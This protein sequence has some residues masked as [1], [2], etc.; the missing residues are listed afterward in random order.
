MFDYTNILNLHEFQIEC[1]EGRYNIPIIK[2]EKCIPDKLIDFCH[3]LRSTQFSSGVHFFLD[4]NRFE[5]IWRLPWRY[6]PHLR[7]FDVVLSPDFSLYTDMP[8]AMKIWNV[9]RS[10]LLG[11]MMQ[12][13]GCRVIPTVSWAYVDS[14]DYC[15]EGIIPGSVVAVSTVG[16]MYSQECRNIF[17]RGFEAMIEKLNPDKIILYGKV[18][19]ELK[20]GNYEIISFSN[21]SMAW[22][23]GHRGVSYKEKQ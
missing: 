22:K 12:R 20:S 21:T 2:T 4:D 6:I 13:S 15:F 8:Q 16:T 18:P 23:Y 1:S 7:N 9:Y 14:F 5:R 3:S 19:D 17:L 10:R 11:Q